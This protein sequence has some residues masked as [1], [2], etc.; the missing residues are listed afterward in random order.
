MLR[1]A[2]RTPKRCST[3]A[4]R[5]IRRQRTTPSVAG[6]GPVSTIVASSRN[7]SS[8]NRGRRPGSGRLTRPAGPSALSR[9][10]RSLG[11]LSPGQL[12]DPPHRRVCRSIPRL[13]AASV[14]LLPSSTSASASIRRDARASFSRDASRRRSDAES[15][16]RVISTAIMIPLA[17]QGVNHSL[18]EM[19]TVRR[20][21]ASCRW[22]YSVFQ[23]KELFIDAGLLG[24][25]NYIAHGVAQDIDREELDS[26]K[27]EL[28]WL[29]DCFRNKVENAA[30]NSEYRLGV[31]P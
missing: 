31:N 17:L 4:Q 3:T 6:S 11:Q 12:P 13:C 15:S 23:P 18:T 7:C 30:I 28:I 8:F 1:S 20:V 9:W 24:K 2:S 29:I 25:R 14:R 22:Y 5:S 10:T 21:R 27:D 16:V 19:G 26:V